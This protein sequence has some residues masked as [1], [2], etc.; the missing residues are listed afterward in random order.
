MKKPQRP[1]HRL[2]D[3]RLD[4]LR[5]GGPGLDRLP[6]VGRHFDELLEPIR[7]PL[8]IGDVAAEE[9]AAAVELEIEVAAIR[10]RL[11]KELHAT[12]LPDFLV[13]LRS[14]AAHVAV[15]DA[16]DAVDS[17]GVV[18]QPGGGAGVVVAALRPEVL[19]LQGLGLLPN[20]VW[21]LRV[22]R[23][24]G[25]GGSHN[26]IHAPYSRL[27]SLAVQ[28]RKGSR[29]GRCPKFPCLGSRGHA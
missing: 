8:G 22:Q 18:E 21:P 24:S 4:A 16:E 14:Q 10:L 7:R 25:A 11:R 2:R 6:D 3:L 28:C 5:Q 12:V 17:A 19:N 26:V 9:R 27:R 20:G 13:V 23:W 1:D 15:L 29:K